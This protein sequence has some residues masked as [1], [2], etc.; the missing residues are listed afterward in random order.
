MILNEILATISHTQRE[1]ILEHYNPNHVELFTYEEVGNIAKDYF[2]NNICANDE[3]VNYLDWNKY[4]KYYI[5]CFMK[6]VKAGNIKYYFEGYIH[7]YF[8]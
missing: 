6:Q 7:E 4:T 2:I 1:A 8:R 5:S 3:A